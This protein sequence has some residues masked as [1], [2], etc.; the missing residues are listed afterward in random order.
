MFKRNLSTLT[1]RMYFI[2]ELMMKLRFI[3]LFY[4]EGDVR[5]LTMSQ[6]EFA[7]YQYM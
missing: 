6:V 5:F 4:L 3:V 7:N 2:I 1:Y